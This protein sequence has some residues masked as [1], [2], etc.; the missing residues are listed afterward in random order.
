MLIHTLN[1]ITTESGYMQVVNEQIHM[2]IHIVS[3]HPED[4]FQKFKNLQFKQS[5]RQEDVRANNKES[6]SKRTR[7]CN[8]CYC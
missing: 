8:G 2:K 5:P 6:L 3:S 7:R 4:S 1:P